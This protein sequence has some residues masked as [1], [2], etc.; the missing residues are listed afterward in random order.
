MHE[1]CDLMGI[2]KTR[3]SAY[4][5]QRDGQV[6]DQNRK[7]QNMLSK[8]VSNHADDWDQWLDPVVFAYNTSRHDS[9]GYFPYEMIFGRTPRMPLSLRSVCHYPVQH[10]TE[11]TSIPHDAHCRT[12]TISAL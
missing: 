2:A 7:L 10:K 12:Y 1:L 5:P 11:N 4:H 6:E 3:T 8:F 9:T